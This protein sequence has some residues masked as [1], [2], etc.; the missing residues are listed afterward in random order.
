[1]ISTATLDK[2]LMILEDTMPGATTADGES[3]FKYVA[4]MLPAPLLATGI[5]PIKPECGVDTPGAGVVT[6][7]PTTDDSECCTA[8]MLADPGENLDCYARFMASPNK[9][10]VIVL[11][12]GD[13]VVPKGYSLSAKIVVMEAYFMVEFILSD[14]QLYASAEMSPINIKSGSGDTFLQISR[15]EDETDKG[16]S[17]LIDM[18]T[19]PSA[20]ININGYIGLPMLKIG[21]AVSIELDAVGVSLSIQKT[22]W[23]LFDC[24]IALSWTWDI[25]NPDF[26][27]YASVEIA[28]VA[29][30]GQK[31]M[32]MIDA[33][34]EVA[35]GFITQ[36]E[37][38]MRQIAGF[39]SGICQK[40]EAAGKLGKLGIAVCNG[41]AGILEGF[42]APLIALASA[43]ANLVLDAIEYLI[44]NWTGGALDSAAK[45]ANFFSVQ[46]MEFEGALSAD[47]AF[48]SAS[49]DLTFMGNQ[50]HAELSVDVK[51]IGQSIWG[52]VKEIAGDL[53]EAVTEKWLEVKDKAKDILEDMRKKMLENKCGGTE[54]WGDGETCGAKCKCCANDETRWYGGGYGNGGKKACG[55]QACWG[56]GHDCGGNS[57]GGNCCSGHGDRWTFVKNNGQTAGSVGNNKCGTSPCWPRDTICGTVC[58]VDRGFCCAFEGW[59]NKCK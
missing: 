30:I 23:L 38:L 19:T 11:S 5:Y 3:L 56:D 57:C 41:I 10:Q 55:T 54:G 39:A 45:M 46:Y 31:G 44:D 12:G 27:F 4:D 20:L 50:H 43:A 58:K 9:P 13:L 28:S 35:R 37:N 59:G 48:I 22:M 16:A 6:E 33:M 1:M 51:A 34:I 40:L 15:S 52:W 29:E 42:V 2:I 47:S 14:T 18:Q 24:T 8:K 21:A 32:D 36:V 53:T 25:A 49:I 7:D 17:F 26:K